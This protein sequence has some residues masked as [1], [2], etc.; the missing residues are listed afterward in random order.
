MKKMTKFLALAIVMLAFS[1]VTFAQVTAT[2][3]A[4]AT[5]VTP[6]AITKTFDLS[7]G[8]VAVSGVAGTVKMDLADTRTVLGGVTL[9]A[10]TGTVTSAKFNVTGSANLTYSISLPGAIT[11]TGPGAPMSL[12][13][14]VSSPSPT[15]TLDGSGKETIILGG[16][17]HVAAGQVAGAYTNLAGCIVTVDYN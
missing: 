3:T 16:T 12:D 4:S 7:F 13:S 5:I 11:L 2:A 14:W 17:L 9:P 1:A 8:N 15:G 6:I 10:V